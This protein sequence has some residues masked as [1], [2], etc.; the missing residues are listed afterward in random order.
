MKMIL[1]DKVKQK[2]YIIW[3]GNKPLVMVHGEEYVIGNKQS[4]WLLKHGI[5][6]EVEY[7]EVVPEIVEPVK[8]TKK[9]FKRKKTGVITEVEVPEEEVTIKEEG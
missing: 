3:Q 5:A 9:S 8:E 1:T 7:G 6:K 2:E 4:A